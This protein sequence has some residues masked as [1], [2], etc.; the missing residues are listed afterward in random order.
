MTPFSQCFL[1]A[2]VAAMALVAVLGRTDRAQRIREKIK[3]LRSAAGRLQLAE[4]A[5]HHD[6]IDPP[7]AVRLVIQAA[8]AAGMGWPDIAAIFNNTASEARRAQ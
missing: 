1:E 6:Q 7:D 3:D 2:D 4:L 5:A 8:L